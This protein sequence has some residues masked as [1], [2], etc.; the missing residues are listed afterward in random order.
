MNNSDENQVE[1]AHIT[2]I[3][4]LNFNI[5]KRKLKR[6]LYRVEEINTYKQQS[7][8]KAMFNRNMLRVT[9]GAVLFSETPS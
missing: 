9:R 1:N 4:I 8:V 6:P 7:T 3:L 2:H 5:K